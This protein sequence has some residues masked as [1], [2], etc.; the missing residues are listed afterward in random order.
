[1]ALFTG[2]T[3]WSNVIRDDVY[4]TIRFVSLPNIIS[5]WTCEYGGI[6]GRDI[7]DFGCGEGTTAI[8][9]ALQHGPKRVVGVEIHP[10]M[11]RCEPLAREQ[12]GL[13]ALPANLHLRRVVPGSVHDPSDRFD[14][15][16]SW[17]VFEHLERR[18]LGETFTLLP[19][20]A[21]TRRGS[22][23]PGHA[24]VLFR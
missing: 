13:T 12:L 21:E 24:L 17:S 4:K 3:D 22:V 2:D 19:G 23:H 9:L 5:D 10:E 20:G 15:I 6:R 16:Y 1:M 18:L 14:V 7:L 8:G 11:D